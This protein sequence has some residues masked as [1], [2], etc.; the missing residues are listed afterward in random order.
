[1]LSKQELA[2]YGSGT[3]TDVFL[4]RVFQECVTYSG[5]MDYKSYLDFVLALENR[6][7]PQALQYIFRILDIKQKGYLN[8]FDINYF[9]RAIQKQ[10]KKYGHE[11]VS[12]RDIQDEIY[13]MIKPID[14]YR[15]ALADLI[16][17][18][19]GETVTNILIDLN[20]FW[21]HE[22][23]ESLVAEPQS[24]ANQPASSSSTASAGSSSEA[25]AAE[26]AK[27]NSPAAKN[28][29]DENNDDTTSTNSDDSTSGTTTSLSTAR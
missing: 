22:N 2:R 15:I 26:S 11:A 21:T 18:G 12:L 10:L 23:R 9:F 16:N 27:P 20:S 5:E 8:P 19:H 17:S 7:E 3:L 14:Q 25:N 13:D 6:N 28:D 24:N 4:D 1:M 29:E